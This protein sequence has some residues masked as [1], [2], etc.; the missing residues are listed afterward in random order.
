MTAHLLADLLK[1]TTVEQMIAW[2]Q[3]PKPMPNVPFGKHKNVPWTEAP[4][5]YLQWMVR[6]TDMDQDA[7]RNA[8]R[9]LVRRAP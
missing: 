7:V 3:E 4:L 2:T 1:I 9:E 5:D 8:K 6:Q